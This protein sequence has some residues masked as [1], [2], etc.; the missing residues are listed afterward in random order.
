MKK[1]LSFICVIFIIFAFGSCTD[2]DDE[3][4]SSPDAGGEKSTENKYPVYYHGYL[5][6]NISLYFLNDVNDLPYVE[7]DDS[8]ELL[9]FLYQFIDKPIELKVSKS[10]SI[11]TLVRQ[12]E[13]YGVNIPV[14]IDFEKDTICF[15]DYDMFSMS[16]SRS[17]ILDVTSFDFFDQGKY[18]SSYSK[19]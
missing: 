6:A 9:K 8:V 3:S 17:T 1:I 7:V 16:P 2:S 15:Q 14:T 5:T 19:S 13:T 10:G 12:N 11:V 4:G 18:P